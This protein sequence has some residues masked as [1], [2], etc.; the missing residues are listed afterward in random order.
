MTYEKTGKKVNSET[1]A[2][3]VDYMV[4]H[5]STSLLLWYIIKKHRFAVVASW[6]ILITVLYVFPPLPDLIM[7]WL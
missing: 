1:G 2:R 6:A 3:A 5:T 7:S 4:N